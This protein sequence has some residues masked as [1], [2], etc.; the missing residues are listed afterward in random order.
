MRGDYLRLSVKNLKHRGLRSWLTLLGIF[1]GIVAVVSLI[2][3][4]TGLKLAVGAQFGVSST[5]VITVQAGGISGF[6]APG[7]G[8]VNKL[9]LDDVDAIEK[10][11]S[12]E[13][14]LPRII[15]SGKM[16]FNDR[17]SIGM[18]GS[19]PDGEERKLIYEVL[20]IEVEVGRLLKDGDTN[21]V[22]LGYN[23]YANGD[24]YGKKI[25]PGNKI[26]IMDEKFQVIGVTKKSGSF[27]LDNVVMMNEDKLRELVDYE[28]DVDLIVVKVKNKDLMDKAVED[29]EKLLRQRRDVE[30]GKE[31]FEVST[32]QAMM[33]TVNNI[34][35][36][37]QA[38][39][40]IIAS[41]SILVGAL[42][43]VNTMTTSVLERRK[44]IGIM[45]AI[46]AKNSQIFMQFF[47][48][49][50]L[51]GL[52]GGIAGV[53]VGVAIGY[54]GTI[55]IGSF[56]GTEIRPNIDFVLI[57]GALIGS[58]VVGSI[59]GIVPAMDAAKQNPVEAL[60]G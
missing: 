31:D 45:K 34:L 25:L 33:E 37:V 41:I 43:I 40:V 20:D 44:E 29:I 21:K 35:G 13:V 9:T 54:F 38:F 32:P 11:S 59:A 30:I 17:I 1:I 10:I 27:I 36:G 28:E 55:G 47:V 53:V 15:S 26:L 60:R 48:E 22:V 39:I 42:G 56:I 18:I 19:V 12:V 24:I 58:F 5:E 52:I 7:S 2:S 8:A 23:F 50:G 49:S 51:L 6:G 4:G 3:L 57:G 14:A 16:E 46:G